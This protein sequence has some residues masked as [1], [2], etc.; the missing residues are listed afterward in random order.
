M[1]NLLFLLLFSTSF[2]YGQTYYR[3]Q[4]RRSNN[5]TEKNSS[6]LSEKNSSSINCDDALNLILTRG[7]YL[8]ESLGGYKEDAIEK[9]KW[10]SYD[11]TLYSIVYFKTKV[12]KG[13]I[14]G[15]WKYNFDNYSTLKNSFESAESKG[16]FF[17]EYIEYAK[18]DCE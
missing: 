1:K 8:D 7:R 15:G 9:I 5:Q 3:Y 12:Y 17:W 11:N 4:E 16:K 10:Y 6:S 18:I 14:Y 2:T 13:Y